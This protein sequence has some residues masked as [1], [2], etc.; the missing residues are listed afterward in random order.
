MRNKFIRIISRY[1]P[2]QSVP[3]CTNL[4]DRNRFTL[5]I[6]RNRTSKLG[7]YRFIQPENKHVVTVNG[8]LN[9]LA[10]LIT[11]I[12]EIAH[13]F[14]QIHHGR[15]VKPHGREWKMA[16]RDLMLPLLNPGVFPDDILRILAKHMRNPKASSQSDPD[17]AKVLHTYDIV[18]PEGWYLED[19]IAGE[20]FY[21]KKRHYKK[22]KTNR[23]R[24]ICQ[25]VNSGRKY[26]I[27]ESV[28]VTKI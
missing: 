9:R 25:D 28:V 12:H 19:L 13:M 17:L 10:F 6:T 27:A 3:Y 22:L 20:Q 16:F 8:S 11:L 26:L 1:I 14:I 18:L 5:K 15:N 21:F 2:E 7:D 24:A 23:T 4:W